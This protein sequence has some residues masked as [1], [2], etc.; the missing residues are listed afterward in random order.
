MEDSSCLLIPF[1]LFEMSPRKEKSR[2]KYNLEYHLLNAYILDKNRSLCFSQIATGSKSV[3]CKVP[4]LLENIMQTS[5][6]WP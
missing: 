2:V 3:S 6:W 4:M 1:S 5:S